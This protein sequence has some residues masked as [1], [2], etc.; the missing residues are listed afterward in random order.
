MNMN[1]CGHRN[2]RK[3]RDIKNSDKY[4]TLEILFKFGSLD[5]MRITSSEPK[6]YM[7]ISVK[8]LIISLG[9]KTNVG[10]KKY[11]K[12]RYAI[13]NVSMKDLSK[14]I[15]EFEKLPYKG[16]VLKR[17]KMEPIDSYFYL[18]RQLA[19]CMMR[20]DALNLHIKLLRTEMTGM[21]YIP[22][23]HICDSDEIK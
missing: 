18:E 10:S 16:Y 20:T 8:G 17:S 6:D 4:I 7:G 12:A 23:L 2:D 21:Q 19:K 22:V 14:I 1:N 11:K 3:H 5:N 9:L 13:T 15:K